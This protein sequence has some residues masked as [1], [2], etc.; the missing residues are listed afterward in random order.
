MQKISI[1]KVATLSGHKDSIYA[2]SSSQDNKNIFSSGAEG[3]VVVWDMTRPGD[4]QLVAKVPN[5]VYAMANCE[6][7]DLLLVGHNYDGL[8]FIDW[9]NREEKATLQLTSKQIFDIKVAENLAY[10]GTGDGEFIVADIK[11]LRVH[12]Q[13][14]FSDK[15]LRAIA[16]HPHLDQIALGFSDNFIRIINSK[17]YKLMKEYEGHQNSVFSLRYSPDGFRL[18]SGSRD[19]SLKMWNVDENFELII[20]EIAHMNTINDIQFSPDG[21]HFVTCS[22]DK[23]IKLWDTEN[24]DLLKV[25]DNDRY[26]SHTSS[27]NKLRWSSYENQLVSISDDRAIMIW[28]IKFDNKE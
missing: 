6:E 12:S 15:S 28:D 11:N 1:N 4:G 2:L 18:L 5:S 9:K 13:T 20:S 22:M 25:I 14:K 19:A 17:S 3:Y 16:L 21:K 23:T 27:V 8:H 7:Q 26:E 24:F 10:V